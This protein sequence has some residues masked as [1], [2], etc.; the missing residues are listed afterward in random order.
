LLGKA[1]PMKKRILVVDDE[2]SFTRLLKLNLERTGHYDVRVEN[3]AGAAAESARQF[4]PDLVILD[5]IM[6]QIFGGDVASQFQSDDELKEIPIVFLSAAVKKQRVDEH[7]GEIGGY[8]FIAKPA[9]L[10]TVIQTIEKYVKHR[11]E[12]AG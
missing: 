5:V 7:E 4:K 3:W 1:R 9:S 11:P 10:E 12:P 2:E 6:P 8:P